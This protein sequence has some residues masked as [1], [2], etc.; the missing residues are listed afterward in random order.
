MHILVTNDDGVQ[1]PGLLALAQEMR[2]LGKVTVFAPD[3]N[4]SASGHVKTMDRPLRVRETTLADGSSAYT[5]DGAPSDCVALPLLGLIHEK[6]DIVV[7]GINPNA[8]LGHDVTYSGTVTAAMEAVIDGLPG[9]AVS[10]DSPENNKSKLDYS[11]AASVARQVT[12]RVLKK[13]LPEGVVLNVNVP[14]LPKDELKGFMITR[15]GLR[16]YRDELDRR[17]DPR[18]RPYYW[19]GGQAPTGVDEPG[20][21][22]GALRAGYVSITPLQLDLTHH[23][24]VDELKKWKF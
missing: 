9:I 20:T 21:D 24:M 14:Y 2:K 3:K 23:K 8:N 13:G 22:F 6:I 18:G 15:Q 1:A 10:L 4:W 19:I 17:L 16:L 7:S 12:R 5:S 11:A